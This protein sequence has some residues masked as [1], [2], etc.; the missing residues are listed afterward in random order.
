MPSNH[1]TRLSEVRLSMLS[2]RFKMMFWYCWYFPRANLASH[3][4]LPQYSAMAEPLAPGEARPNRVV[5]SSGDGRES[6]LARFL[7]TLARTSEI[8]YTPKV[9]AVRKK[10]YDNQLGLRHKAESSS[11]DSESRKPWLMLEKTRMRITP[12]TM[13]AV[14]RMSDVV[15]A[16]S[17]SSAQV[18]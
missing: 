1:C 12:S 13:S 3:L 18:H 2:M 5:G 8:R 11:I 4:P 10:K 7:E 16:R 14:P 17:Q 9:A 6:R 15:T